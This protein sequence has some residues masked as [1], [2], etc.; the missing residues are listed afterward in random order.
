MR[1]SRLESYESILEALVSRPLTPHSLA[2]GTHLDHV[3]LRH[4]LESLI[5]N[6]LIEERTTEKT[7]FYAVTEKGVAVIRTL[8]FQKYLRR[9]KGAIRAVDEAVEIIPEISQRSCS[10]EKKP[11]N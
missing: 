10:L 5:R 9:L 8:D 6:G 4:C 11:R 3:L 2:A 7:S 1:K